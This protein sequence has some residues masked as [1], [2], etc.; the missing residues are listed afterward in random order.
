[1]VTLYT[2][3]KFVGLAKVRFCNIFYHYK[4]SLIEKEQPVSCFEDPSLV[5]DLAFLIDISGHVNDLN[6]KLQGSQLISELYNILAFRMKLSLS[7][8]QLLSN[9]TCHFSNCHKIL[10]QNKTN[11][12]QY[13]RTH[14]EQLQ[15]LSTDRFVDVWTED[16]S[17]HLLTLLK[18]HMK[19]MHLQCNHELRSK[20]KEGDLLNF[21]SS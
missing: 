10:H 15:Q 2:S 3:V 4:V 14:T 7:H 5:S 21:L 12:D 13:V 19:T 11:S 17:K 9:N 8:S 20:F 1:M 16:C 6:S 18:H